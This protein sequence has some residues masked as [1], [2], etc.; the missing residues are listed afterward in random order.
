[1][2]LHF[3]VP[4][5]TNAEIGDTVALT[6][7]EAKHASVVRRVRVGETITLG[8][9]KGTWLEGTVDD[10]SPS[11]VTVR[12]ESR[13]AQDVP[14]T[15]LLLAQALAKGDR[16]ELA[17]QAACE[18][19]VDEVIP[20]QAARSVSRWEGPKAAKGRERW[21]SIVREAAKQAHRAWVPEVAAVESTALLAKRLPDARMLILDPWTSTRLSTIEPDERDIVLVVG[22]E[23]GIA[24]EELERLE[25]AGAERVKLGDTVLRTSTAGPAAIAVLSAILGRW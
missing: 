8:D 11:H 15:R 18:L 23:G 7:A 24:P 5:C 17:V 9:G 20:W 22:P 12:I 3:I 1:M 19:G 21:A 2:A 14:G 10:V 6:G 25:A 4:D 13:S 16:D